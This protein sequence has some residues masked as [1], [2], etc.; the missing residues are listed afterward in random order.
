MNLNIIKNYL[1]KNNFSFSENEL[2]SNYTTFQ[3]GGLAKVMVFPKNKKELINIQEFIFKNNIPFFYL[4]GGSNILVSDKGIDKLI[5]HPKIEN[6][7][8]IIS[9]NKENVIVETTA[10]SRG[11][12]FAKKMQILGFSGVEFLSTIPGEIGGAVI[13]NAGCFGTE[14][15]DVVCEIKAV[16]EGKLIVYENKD[17]D[18]SYR[19]SFFK[20][21]PNIWILSA[22]F[23]LKKKTSKEIESLILN[24][25]TLRLKSQ[26]KN[27]KS[28][29]S[30][31]KNPENSIS[32]ERAWQL[33][34]KAGLKGKSFG[35]AVI[36]EKHCNF[37]L[38]E[39][40]AKSSDIYSLICLVE[41][42]VKKKFGISLEKEVI[43][44][45]D[46]A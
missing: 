23:L 43:L 16:K 8:N 36:S 3:T 32:N 45:G 29:G 1:V 37:I 5:I 31:F 19:N 12:W 4:G 41:E 17:A 2:M 7:Y 40:K 22:S 13:Q 34:E 10:V 24:Y 21:N 38:N 6:T 26:P 39:K 15:K 33:I 30:I 9:E 14:I 44:L 46:F 11:G 20:K 25:K 35:G 27:K 28:A 42:E 18:F